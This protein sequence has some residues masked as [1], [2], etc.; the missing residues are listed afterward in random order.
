MTL[1]APGADKH[2][3]FV[4]PALRMG[5]MEK[6]LLTVF[7]G[8]RARLA[9][10]KVEILTFLPEA[11]PAI[12]ERLNELDV[13]VHTIDR[14][15]MSFPRFFWRLVQHIHARSPDLV[16]AFLAGSTG[17]WGR[18]AARLAGVK[19]VILSDLALDP[20]TT[21][22]QR[23]LEPLLIRL[24]A[25]YITNAQSTAER[26]VRSGVPAGKVALLRNAID[27]GKYRL[28]VEPPLRAAWGLDDGQLVVGFLGMLRP[29]KR[30][31]LLLDALLLMPEESRPD[32]VV[33]AGDGPLRAELENRIARDPWLSQHCTLMGVVDDVPAYLSS[34]DVLALS[35]DTESLPN[36]ILEAM[37]AGVPCVA[38]NVA[39][40][41]LL[42]GDERFLAEPRNPQ[43]F[44]DS[45]SRMLALDPGER[46]QV[47]NELRR[48]AE[49]EFDL[50]A[51][52]E[53]FWQLH[54]DL[55]P[56]PELGVAR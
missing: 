6:Q 56:R 13:P 44:A 53:R 17:T 35:S 25:R 38:T 14:S 47:G 41:P 51:S 3:I 34:I 30:P 15:S 40:V 48:R 9:E 54:D 36:A 22:T 19:V 21:R 27:V 45:L 52:A 31:Q 20:M 28:D 33:F 11:H 29:E 16:H 26:L 10:H 8:A 2:A 39:D 5:G 1:P 46:A 18:L 12:V 55:W 50:T 7:E 43:S 4:L 49:A 32:H 42:V 37:A 23:L 24:T